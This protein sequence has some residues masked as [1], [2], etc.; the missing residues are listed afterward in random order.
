MLEKVTSLLASIMFAILS[1]FGLNAGTEEPKY[2][3]INRIGSEIEIRQYAPRVAAEY[4]IDISG[5]ENPR[6]GAFRAIAGY[7]FGAN[8]GRKKIDMTS[9]VEVQSAGSKIAMTTPVEVNKSQQQM[10]MRF[11]MPS[12]YKLADLPQP[13]N[14]KVNLVEIPEA[15]VAALVFSGSTD[16]QIIA[17]KKG[18]LIKSLKSTSYKLNGEPTAYLYNPPWTI[19]FLRRNEV[20]VA[21]EKK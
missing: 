15:T 16:D 1:T 6:S 19:P 17:A 13:T 9:P 10:T 12:Q 5:A 18:E 11:F 3:V 7:I 2:R 8:K 20:I 4:T 14:P 21:V